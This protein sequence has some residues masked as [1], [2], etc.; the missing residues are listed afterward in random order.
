MGR[1]R[2]E[3]GWQAAAHLGVVAGEQA[4]GHGPHVCPQELQPLVLVA[5]L[6]HVD[7]HGG[8]VLVASSQPRVLWAVG[9]ELTG[10]VPTSSP[11]APRP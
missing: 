9:T 6:L 5:H 11:L 4:L 2:R 7:V 1:W 10:A 3:Q 8:H